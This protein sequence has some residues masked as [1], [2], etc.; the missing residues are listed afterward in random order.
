[1]TF[2]AEIRADKI[3]LGGE[4]FLFTQLCFDDNDDYSVAFNLRGGFH[5]FHISSGVTE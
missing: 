3:S 5:F 4:G 1:M 2:A